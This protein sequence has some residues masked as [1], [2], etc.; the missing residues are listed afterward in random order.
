MVLGG[1]A[2]VLCTSEL[3][4]REKEGWQYKYDELLNCGP[5]FFQGAMIED[6]MPRFTYNIEV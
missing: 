1:A 3:R 4:T 2:K 6:K 5:C